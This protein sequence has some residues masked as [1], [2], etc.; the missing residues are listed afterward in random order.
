MNR[1]VALKDLGFT[2][3]QVGSVLDAVS[4]DELRGMLILRRAQ[5]EDQIAAD[6]GRLGGIEA[7]LRTIEK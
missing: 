7:R 3:E 4:A 2:L 6:H 5:I 1:L